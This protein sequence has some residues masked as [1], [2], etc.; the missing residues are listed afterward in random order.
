MHRNGDFFLSCCNHVVVMLTGA[1]QE[2]K[3]CH[4]EN[5]IFIFKNNGLRRV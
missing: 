1:N 5:A 3:K 2:A 4:G